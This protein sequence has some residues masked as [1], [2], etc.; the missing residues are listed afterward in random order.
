MVLHRPDIFFI[1]LNFNRTD[2]PKI[3][4][5]RP[6]NKPKNQASEWVS[7]QLCLY[8]GI[9]LSQRAQSFRQNC[10]VLFASILN[11]VFVFL[12][13]E[14]SSEEENKMR[15]KCVFTIHCWIREQSHRQIAIQIIMCPHPLIIHLKCLFFFPLEV[16]LC[17]HFG[18]RLNRDL[19]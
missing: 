11:F 17:L 8:L 19:C 5:R 4:A 3:D 16:Y 12:K 9:N 14:F 6:A 15:D 1:Y 10:N 13:F 7:N 2:E 18:N